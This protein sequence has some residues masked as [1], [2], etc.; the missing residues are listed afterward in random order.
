MHVPGLRA[1]WLLLP[2]ATL[3]LCSPEQLHVLVQPLA[4]ASGRFLKNPHP[5]DEGPGTAFSRARRPT[6]IAGV[7][8]KNGSF[9]M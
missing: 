3:P 9:I 8:T 1:L 2:A 5:A 4:S 6:K 7:E